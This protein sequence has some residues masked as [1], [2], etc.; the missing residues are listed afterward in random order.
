MYSSFSLN[1]SSPCL[2]LLAPLLFFLF[3]CINFIAIG[4]S[5]ILGQSTAPEEDVEKKD[6]DKMAIPEF[7]GKKVLDLF[8][9]PNHAEANL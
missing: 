5:V 7:I 4:D 9:K 1:H 6:T 3:F 2:L 8:R